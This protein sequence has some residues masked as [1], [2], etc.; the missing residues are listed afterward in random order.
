VEAASSRARRA[1]ALARP[2]LG[3]LLLRDG[4]LT[5]DQLELALAIREESG[6]RLGRIVVE[7]GLASGGAVARLLA[8]QHDLE[9][10]DVSS[11][12]IDPAAVRLLPERLV[13]H[14]GALPVSFLASDLLLVAVGDPTDIVT[15][16]ELR[17]ALGTRIQIAVADEVELQRALSRFFRTDARDLAGSGDAPPTVQVVDD[18]I[19][20]ALEAGASD[21]HF[22]PET[23]GLVVRAR[24]DGVMRRLETVSAVDAPA[25]TGRLK[26]MAELDIAERR[27]PQDGGASV[28]TGGRTVDARLTVLPTPA[29]E[30]VILRFHQRADTR[31]A[32][33]DLGMTTEIESAFVH[34]V[35][36][37]HGAVVVCGPTGSGKTT[38]LYAA[39]DL[40]NDEG[41]VLTTIEDPVEHHVPGVTQVEVNTRSGLTFARGLRAMLRADTDV[42]LV[43]E[44][45]DEETAKIAM[46]ASLTGHLVLTTLHAADGL[47]SIARLRDLGV[48]DGMLSAALRCVVAQR[49]ARRLCT[50]CA[51]S[52]AATDEEL[53]ELDADGEA[54][55]AHPA[56]C[57]LCDGTGYRGRIGIYELLPVTGAVRSAL[58]GGAD[59]LE[60]AV[61]E[62]GMRPLRAEAQ[63]LCL[64]GVTSLDEVRRVAGDRLA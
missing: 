59:E 56:G 21:L 60:R 20:R 36:Q 50:A 62:A 38:T 16:D 7:H 27:L 61:L 52:R 5:S 1:Q 12:A 24:I 51:V 11:I 47:G 29:G 28:E 9:F 37:P 41:R 39:L 22:E 35:R 42:L 40:L 15:S 55:L 32:L 4:H 63:R 33:P 13:R 46:Q 19:A 2:R 23:S 14:Y 3:A 18:L 53:A 44:I 6:E 26:V 58:A 25:V 31:L 64:A 45:R 17:M 8:E 57:A 49:L 43:G 34:A 48:G 10:V 30:K 54:V